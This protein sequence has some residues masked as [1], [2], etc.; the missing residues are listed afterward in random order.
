MRHIHEYFRAT[1]HLR[2][3]SR[4]QYGLY[5]KG[6][7]VKYEDAMNFWRDEF[8]KLLDSNQFEKKYSYT[9]KHQYGKVGGMTNYS[10][11]SCL[12]IINS[13]VS[14]GDS[15]GCPF[16]HWDPQNLKLKFISYG[17]NKEGNSFLM[18]V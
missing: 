9:F 1:H 5:I 11:Y 6:I 17:I 10:P 3:G 2:H 15:H 12:K 7:G 18:Y 4:L 14:S 13:T 16:K 8:T